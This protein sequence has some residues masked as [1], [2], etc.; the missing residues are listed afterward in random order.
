MTMTSKPEYVYVT[1]IQSTPE[2]VF[3]ALS[4]AELTKL[5][6]GVKKNVSDWKPG[7]PWAH[8][9]YETNE[10]AVSGEVLEIDPPK[11]LVITWKSQ[12]IDEPASKVT[13]LVE[14]QFGAVKL[15]V[16]HEQLGPKMYEGVSQGWPAVLSSLKTLLESG[17]PM[18]MTTRRWGK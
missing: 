12:Q 2:K 16:T 8:Q 15:T 4:D 3:G 17:Q 13:F 5:Y 1:Y 11:R 9:D 10:V 7:S 6:W 14:S 18:P